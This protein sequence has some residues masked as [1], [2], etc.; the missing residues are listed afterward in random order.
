MTFVPAVKCSENSLWTVS[1][2]ILVSRSTGIVAGSKKLCLHTVPS[3]LASGDG[4]SP[5]EKTVNVLILFLIQKLSKEHTQYGKHC[6]ESKHMD[7]APFLPLNLHPATGDNCRVP[8]R[9]RTNRTNI[10]HKGDLLDH[11]T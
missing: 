6:L 9:N 11:L 4:L 1:C 8:E 7:Y 2:L 10:L 5:P 3:G